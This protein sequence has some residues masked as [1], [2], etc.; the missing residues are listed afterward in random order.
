MNKEAERKIKLAKKRAAEATEKAERIAK[1]ADKKKSDQD[2]DEI[3]GSKKPLSL[4]AS[5][6][7]DEADDE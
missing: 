3:G 1:E 6:E 7:L 4:A 5:T 2:I